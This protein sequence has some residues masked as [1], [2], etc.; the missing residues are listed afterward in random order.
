[1]GAPARGSYLELGTKIGLATRLQQEAFVI[2]GRL[3]TL[4]L[5]QLSQ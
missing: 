2:V 1:M 3:Y 5:G 4:C